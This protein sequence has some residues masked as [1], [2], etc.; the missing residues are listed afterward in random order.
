MELRRRAHAEGRKVT[1]DHQ[2][3]CETA[4]QIVASGA[5]ALDDFNEHFGAGHNRI[6]LHILLGSM[7]PSPL[8]A[9]NGTGDPRREAVKQQEGGTT[10]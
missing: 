7:Q 2:P 9:E 1:E 3:D 6:E 10:N 4:R 8:R 5:D